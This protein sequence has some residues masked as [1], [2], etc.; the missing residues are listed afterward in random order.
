MSS[1]ERTTPTTM[2]KPISF[3]AKI[4]SQ[5]LKAFFSQKEDTEEQ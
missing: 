4:S 1:L 3:Q 2:T 5:P